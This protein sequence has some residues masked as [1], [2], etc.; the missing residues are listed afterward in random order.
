MLVGYFNDD[1]YSDTFRYDA[2]GTY[3]SVRMGDGAG[4]WTGFTD[5]NWGSAVSTHLVGYFNDGKKSDLLRYD[6]ST[7]AF[8]T[9]IANGT[10]GWSETNGTFDDGRTLYLAQLDQDERTDLILYQAPSGGI[11]TRFSKN[12]GEWTSNQ[13]VT[14]C[15]WDENQTLAVAYL[16]RDANAAP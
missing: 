16:D 6:S 13:C 15:S 7:G 4:N 12:V 2:S 1:R 10:G 5:G 3:W 8:S 11:T 14:N 9:K